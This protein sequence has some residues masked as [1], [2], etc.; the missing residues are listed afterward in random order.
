M[1]NLHRCLLCTDGSYFYFLLFLPGCLSITPSPKASTP[2]YCT[3]TT[4]GQLLYPPASPG[5]LS[6]PPHTYLFCLHLVSAV[7]NPLTHTFTE[8]GS[9]TSYPS[10]KCL[11]MQ[12]FLGCQVVL[13]VF[14]VCIKFVYVGSCLILILTLFDSS[15]QYSALVWKHSP[16]T[17]QSKSL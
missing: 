14:H 4:M 1:L 3:Q 13:S 10:L 5:R 16:L 9:Q 15:A 17:Q 12:A 8:Q 2:S 7:T 6:L 11:L